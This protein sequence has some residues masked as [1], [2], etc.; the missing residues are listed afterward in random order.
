MMSQ[1]VKKSMVLGLSLQLKHQIKEEQL[2]LT[3]SNDKFQQGDFLV[4]NQLDAFVP[5]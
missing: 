3:F 1:I 5:H 2:H 4:T